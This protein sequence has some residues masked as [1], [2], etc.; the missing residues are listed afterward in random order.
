M[1]RFEIKRQL[2]NLWL[3]T[4]Y[5]FRRKKLMRQF[6]VEEHL[7][8]AQQVYGNRYKAICPFH[9]E[10][11][12]SLTIDGDKYRCFGCGKQGQIEAV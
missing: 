10:L 9:A 5:Y 1:S 8:K 11:T 12:P 7:V 4:R 3:L 6:W 2:L